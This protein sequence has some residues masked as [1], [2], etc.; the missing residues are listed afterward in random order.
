MPR[1]INFLLILSDRLLIYDSLNIVN[2]SREKIA[3]CCKGLNRAITANKAAL[4]SNP[5]IIKGFFETALKCLKV[6]SFITLRRV[7]V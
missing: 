7:P 3:W 1:V 2:V 5:M 4:R 6:L